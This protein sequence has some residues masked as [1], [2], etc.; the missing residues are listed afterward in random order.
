MNKIYLFFILLI[1]S[2]NQLF[3]QGGVKGTVKSR[4]DDKVLT[5]ATITLLGTKLGAITDAK[6]NFEIKDVAAGNY[7]LRAS[8]VG[9]E[10][11]EINIVIK[12]K[13]IAIIN[14]S[15]KEFYI[16]SE[17]ISVVASRAEFRETPIAFSNITK[18]D[19]D[20]K[21]GNRELP[22]I[23]NETPG[24]YATESG[25]G[26]GDSRINVRGF[27]QR[28]LAVM[29]NGVPVNDMENGWVYWSNWDGIRDVAS[30]IQV[31]RGLGASRIANPSVGGTLNLITDAAR[32]KAGITLKQDY[33]SGNAL[34]T[35]LIAHTGNLN[36]LAISFMGKRKTRD[37]IVDKT[38]ADAWG[39]Y[40]AISYDL[41]KDQKFDFYVMGTP[42]RHAQRSFRLSI[43]NYSHET[44]FELYPNDLKDRDSII[45]RTKEK[46]ILYNNHWGPTTIKTKEYYMGSVHDPYSDEFLN[47]RVNY[48]HKPQFNLNWFWRLADNTSLT[49]VFYYSLGNGGGSGRL[50]PSISQDLNEQLNF[51]NT[52]KRNQNN[53]DTRY[54]DNKN[55]AE[56]ILRNSVNN[57]YWFGW[58]S[59]L[60]TK[61]GDRIRFQGGL[62]TRYYIGEHYQE[63]RNL[64]G[65]DYYVETIAIVRNNRTIFVDSTSNMNEIPDKSKWIKYLGD[66][67]SYN[68]DGLI[69]WLG[70]FAQME[71]KDKELTTYLNLSLSNT[72]YKRKDYF[73]TPDAK[74][75]NET[76]WQNFLGYTVKLGANYNLSN[77]I[78]VFGNAGYYSRPPMFNVV[79]D[80]DNGLFLNPLNEKV[81]AL[82][83]GSGYWSKDLKINLNT[84]YTGWKDRSFYRTSRDTNQNLIY[85][86]IAGISA[87][88]TG[89][90]LEIDYKPINILRL[91]GMAS[92]GDWKWTNDVSAN[93]YDE[94][95]R[96]L[97]SVKIYSDGLKVG[98]SAQKTFSLS[99][100]LTPIR[101]SFIN[102]TYKYF[103]DNY[104]D[105][106]PGSRTN[107]FDREQP[108]KMP[109]YGLLD[110]HFGYF[111]K[112]KDIGVGFLDELGIKLHFYNL[113]DTKYIADAEDNR[114]N[115]YT[116]IVDGNRV[117]RHDAY[118]AEVWFG[119]P[120][121]FNIEFELK[122]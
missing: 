9:F 51:D 73:R 58:L 116:K 86:N 75:G 122:L 22:T 39:Y 45:L 48:Y 76:D 38:W 4:T 30:S 40:L 74:N 109:D 79:F 77:S 93:I 14:I 92:I 111:L 102:F 89:I 36:G 28:N 121:R 1:I 84:Y 104:A 11:E 100:T 23:L 113:L 54:L 118:S 5:G 35:T 31:Q 53:I 110:A 52:I 15:L 44:A 63:V 114:N 24:V 17:A 90:E 87:V 25:G 49:N 85:Y 69:N 32:Q 80:N 98:N 26:Y 99:A 46:G 7:V 91:R 82:E 67:I 29:I 95:N 117:P 62:D 78:N 37:G 60:D 57:H 108:W 96:F 115:F 103:M 27:D 33:G 59:T 71:Y 72:G 6:G 56:T 65:G 88:H 13:Q 8:Y 66:K 18:E 97:D 43:P 112:F 70:G 105:F 41:T 42:Q 50:G 119:L 81:I 16:E 68:Y 64:L 107:Q 2:F 94:S 19:L 12:D 20:F 34:S 3:S 21:L 10:P 47:E 83:L 106:N 61:F 120:F 55:R 101:R